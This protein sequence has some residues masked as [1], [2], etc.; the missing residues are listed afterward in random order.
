MVTDRL[1]HAVLMTEREQTE[2]IVYL[3]HDIL[4][5]LVDFTSEH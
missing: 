4:L 1:V 2:D 5:L 3:L